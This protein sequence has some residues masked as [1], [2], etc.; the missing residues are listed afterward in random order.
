MNTPVE[1]RDVESAMLRAVTDGAFGEA[2]LLLSS[3]CRLI[4][5]TDQIVR[6]KEVLEWMFRKSSVA[7]AHAAARLEEVSQ[8]NPY[9]R[10]AQDRLHT[11]QVEG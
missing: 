5:T 8:V 4:V 9:R 7:R 1:L 3:Y 11:W 6:A 2:D 10:M